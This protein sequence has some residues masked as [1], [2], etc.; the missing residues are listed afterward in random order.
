MCGCRETPRPPSDVYVWNQSWSPAVEAAVRSLGPD[1]AALRVLVQEAGRPPVA[2][3]AEALRGRAVVAVLRVNGEGPPDEPTLETFMAAVEALAAQRVDVTQVEFDCDVATSRLGD[4]AR[5]VARWRPRVRPRKLSVT[6]LPAWLEAPELGALAESADELVLQV[7]T[8]RAPVL[9]DGRQALADV[10]RFSQRFGA[11]P[12]RVALPAY[13]A[14]LRDGR[15]VL[16]APHD[17][18]KALETLSDVPGVGGFVWFRL[19]H[20]QDAQ[21]WSVETLRAVIRAEPAVRAAPV[22]AVELAAVPSAPVTS[23]VWVSNLNSVDVAWPG[24]VSVM[25][26]VRHA[27]ATTGYGVQPSGEG[28]DFTSS[29]SGWLHPGERARIG[30]VVGSR[31]AAKVRP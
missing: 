12:F 20:A 9:F 16:A 18:A 22:A 15:P 23:D 27:D 24:R 10:R 25:G 2:V 1:V 31:L 19:G 11:R 13:G 4:W 17:V 26:A 6:A 30:F 14:Q 5:V 21:A 29:L 28:V 3:S 7:H 8:V